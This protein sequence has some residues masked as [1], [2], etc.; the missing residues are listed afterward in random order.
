MADILGILKEYRA[1]GLTQEELTFTQNSL[2]LGEARKYET[3]FQK[4][5]FLSQ[6]QEYGLPEDYTTQQNTMLAKLSVA[7]ANALSTR[8]VPD[9]DK[10]V[11]V[12]VGDKAKVWNGLQRLGYE[13]VELDANGN[14][15]NAENK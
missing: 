11:V 4:A 13:V 6:I 9:V 12:L 1:K 3:G 7:D 8:Y 15:K 10:M 2:S 14:V 5:G